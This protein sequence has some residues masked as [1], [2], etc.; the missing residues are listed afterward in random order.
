MRYDIVQFQR[1]CNTSSGFRQQRG[2]QAS[3]RD[4]RGQAAQAHRHVGGA[5]WG[6]GIARFGF[7]EVRVARLDFVLAGAIAWGLPR[8]RGSPPASTAG[9]VSVFGAGCSG[10]QR[11]TRTCRSRARFCGCRTMAAMTTKKNKLKARQPPRTSGSIG[12]ARVCLCGTSCRC[13]RI[14]GLGPK[15][16]AWMGFRV[17]AVG[18]GTKI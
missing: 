10:W 2:F 6:Q 14:A 11:L 4:G 5:G 1:A 9:T 7:G 17:V 8:L 15:L 16:I 13:P 12:A 3:P 18:H